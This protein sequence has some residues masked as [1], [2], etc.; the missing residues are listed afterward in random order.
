MHC[1]H[2][3]PLRIPECEHGPQRGRHHRRPDG[4]EGRGPVL[5]AALQGG[6]GHLR[7]R[8]EGQGVLPTQHLRYQGERRADKFNQSAK[9]WSNADGERQQTNYLQG[10][11]DAFDLLDDDK[12]ERLFQTYSSRGRHHSRYG[13]D[14]TFTN[15]STKSEVFL[16]P[17]AGRT[18]R[19]WTWGRRGWDSLRSTPLRSRGSRGRSTSWDLWRRRSLIR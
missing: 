9:C 3:G 1:V 2:S 10:N 19:L 18:S 16:L 6:V 5:V 12:S 11:H 15:N 13:G 14:T 17:T 8:H 7:S 4:L